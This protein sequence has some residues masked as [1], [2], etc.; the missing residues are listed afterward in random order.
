MPSQCI[1]GVPRARGTLPHPGRRTFVQL[2]RRVVLARTLKQIV[3][4][5]ERTLGL[6]RRTLLTPASLGGD[7][8]SERTPVPADIG[9]RCAIQMICTAEQMRATA[10]A[11]DERSRRSLERVASMQSRNAML[12]ITRRLA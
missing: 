10:K 3:N 1:G 9:F 6:C 5:S 11:F 8:V 2:Q 7:D 4:Q 12:L